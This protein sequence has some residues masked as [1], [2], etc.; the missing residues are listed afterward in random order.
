MKALINYLITKDKA[1]AEK[2]I[3]SSLMLDAKNDMC[4]QTL[5]LFYRHCK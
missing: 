4:W 3:K 5:G 2:E 1:V